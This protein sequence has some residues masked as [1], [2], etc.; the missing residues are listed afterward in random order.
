LSQKGQEVKKITK[1]DLKK[2]R[3]YLLEKK[4]I[5]LLTFINVGINTALKITELSKMRLEDIKSDW[6]I[7]ILN[8]RNQKKQTIKFNQLCIDSIKQLKAFY[9]EKGFSENKGYLFK[10]LSFHNINQ[11]IDKPI[12]INGISRQFVKLR[13]ILNISYPIGTQSL[14]KTWG[15]YVYNETKDIYLIMRVL[16]KNTPEEALKYIGYSDEDELLD[17]DSFEI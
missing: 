9:K 4:N 2:I 11:K 5:H 17:F 16:N 13:E 1:S 10:S 8:N 3:Q 15:Y 14:S 7:D 12:T 6:S